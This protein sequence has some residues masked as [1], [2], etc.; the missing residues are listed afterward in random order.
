M[1]PTKI[2]RRFYQS[3]DRTRKLKR[4]FA[5]RP[6]R[7]PEFLMLTA[8]NEYHKEHPEVQGIYVSALAEQLDLTV[9]AASKQLRHLEQQGWLVRTVDRQ[10]R[11][12]TF[13]S[14]SAQGQQ[15]LAEE[16]TFYL[17]LSDRVFQQMGEERCLSILDG[18]SDM[19]DLLEEN[20][21][22]EQA[23]E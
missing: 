9:P 4:W 14:L 19:L 17:E 6:M 13:V 7:F 10:N 1:K 8:I 3:L 2:H 18:I 16:E 15:V 5:D 23:L 21:H 20:I 22:Q 11:R 12:N